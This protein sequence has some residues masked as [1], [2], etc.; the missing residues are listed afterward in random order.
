MKTSHREL[1]SYFEKNQ[2]DEFVLERY[3]ASLKEHNVL[4]PLYDEAT[5]TMAGIVKL[6]FTNAIVTDIS[7]CVSEGFGDRYCYEDAELAIQELMEWHQRGFGPKKPQ[8]WVAV[9]ISNGGEY[10]RE[11]FEEH[12][13]E[14]YAQD[15]LPYAQIDDLF[16][17]SNIVNRSEEIGR[18]LGYDLG[19]VKHLAAYLH[20]TRQVY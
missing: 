14:S 3:R 11:S 8:G 19:K 17:Q 16:L 18:A 12:Y 9:A 1:V 6:A 10:L 5:D 4:F 7:A 15:L 13:G 20:Y 2:P